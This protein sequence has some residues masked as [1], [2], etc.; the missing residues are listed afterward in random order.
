MKKSFEDYLSFLE[1]NL[2]YQLFKSQKSLLREVYEGKRYYYCANRY[3]DTH[4][5][6]DVMRRLKEEM[7]RDESNLLPWVY[8]LDGYSTDIVLY[9]EDFK[10]TEWEK[11]NEDGLQ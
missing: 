2:G 5:L 6:Y 9:D 4:W 1:N 7:D 11:E 10:N 8:K 3:T